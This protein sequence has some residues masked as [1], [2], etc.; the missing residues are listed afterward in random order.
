LPAE[1]DEL[2][3][4]SAILLSLFPHGR[5][6]DSPFLQQRGWWGDAFLR[7][8]DDDGFGS[9]LWLLERATITEITALLARAYAEDALAW[10]LDDDLIDILDIQTNA[11]ATS[12]RLN[13]RIAAFTLNTLMS[14]VRMTL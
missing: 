7:D 14:D 3:L 12:G 9:V 11:D 4:Q 6:S 10:M 8:E 1:S 13:M 5:D 2:E